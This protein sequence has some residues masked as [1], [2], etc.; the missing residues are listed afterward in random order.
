MKDSETRC[1]LVATNFKQLSGAEVFSCRFGDRAGWAIILLH[2]ETGTV[3]IESDYGKWI[4]SWPSPGRG[5]CTLREFICHGSYDYMANKFLAGQKERWDKERTIAGI[6]D[7]IA[8]AC[9]EQ[10]I[11][12]HEDRCKELN[13][14]LEDEAP[15]YD[16]EVMFIER[17]PKD[18]HELLGGAPWEY[19]KFDQQPEFYWL[20]DGVLPALVTELRKTMPK[21]EE[22]VK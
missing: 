3:A 21:Q 14:W 2:E 4:F 10:P 20:R 7:A 15:D 19:L 6:S 16:H 22:A 9:D 18:M 17:M 8:E 13:D 12:W 5:Q 1:R 11:T